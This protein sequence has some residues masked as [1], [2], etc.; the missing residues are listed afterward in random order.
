M[1]IV[2]LFIV[3]RSP[4]SVSWLA[5]FFSILLGGEV[6]AGRID[7]V[8]EPVDVV[9]HLRHDPLKGVG[10]SDGLYTT[11]A[12]LLQHVG[13]RKVIAGLN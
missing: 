8:S 13:K 3:H 4:F 10:R 2:S 5:E 7:S 11:L 6:G 12:A 1:I 9:L